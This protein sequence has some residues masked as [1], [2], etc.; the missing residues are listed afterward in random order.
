MILVTTIDIHKKDQSS[1]FDLTEIKGLSEHKWSNLWFNDRDS[2]RIG[3][4][5]LVSMILFKTINI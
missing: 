3:N 1:I 2:E 4:D 5:L